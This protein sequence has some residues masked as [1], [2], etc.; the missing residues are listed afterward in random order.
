M[1]TITM[2]TGKGGVGKTTCAAATA[3]HH[4]VSGTTLAISTDA[5][6]SLAHIFEIRDNRKPAGV[7]PYLDI[8]E[9]GE[10]EFK[11]MW[12][13]RFGREV[14]EVF[15]TFVSI[16]YEEFV[17]FMTS[18]L[19]GLGE[20]FMV[21]YIR[22]LGRR[23][24]YEN[25]V[26]DT[27]PLGQT[28]ALLQMPALLG[29]HLRMAP[30]IYSRLKVGR[31]SREP[32]LDIL[33]RW[34]ALSG[35]NMEFLRHEIYFTMVTI[36]EALA[37][38]QLEGVFRELDKFGLKVKQ[39]IINNVV[40]MPDSG[41]MQTRARQQKDYLKH[42]YG[43]YS[44]LKIVELPMFPQEVKGLVRLREVGKILFP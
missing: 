13:D 30:R 40:K 24:K 38:Q 11:E 16:E 37:V 9:L 31:S 2:F 39:L 18:V 10:K 25:V 1:S 23:G 17:D 12:D 20:E 32:V 21:D 4:A 26:W 34:E 15:S 33:K 29:N 3:L 43:R 5:T 35:E 22:E 19:P 7:L 44:H 41:F 6:P 8:N 36:P 28:L 14:Y 42:I 27:A